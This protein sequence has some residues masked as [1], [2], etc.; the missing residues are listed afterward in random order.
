MEI[1]VEQSSVGPIS[2]GLPIAALKSP[3]DPLLRAPS[4]SV[5]SMQSTISVADGKTLALGRM[6]IE[7]TVKS[8]VQRREFVVL[9]APRII[10]AASPGVH[11]HSPRL[12]MA[13]D[14]RT[15][16]A[17]LKP[18]AQARRSLDDFLACA[19][20]FYLAVNNPGLACVVPLRR[21]VAE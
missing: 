16:R 4:I 13:R 3:F 14:V 19:S 10:A 9:V 21:T 17:Q 11:G 15:Q 5:T 6:V 2:E 20:G 1:D 12:F 7:S 8:Q 18:D